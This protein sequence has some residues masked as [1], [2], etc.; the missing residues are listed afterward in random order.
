MFDTLRARRS[1]NDAASDALV[2]LRGQRHTAQK[3]LG[4]ADL[5]EPLRRAYVQGDLGTMIDLALPTVDTFSIAGPPEECQARLA[6]FDGVADRL[7]LGGAWVG[8]SE[9]R[10]EEN[11]RLIM[12]AFAPAQ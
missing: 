2:I 10:L 6:E 1:R 3:P 4:F 11:H 9:A 12:E 5:V 8:P 7:I